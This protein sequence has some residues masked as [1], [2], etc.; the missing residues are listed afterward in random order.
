MTA[1]AA[2]LCPRH[3]DE[4]RMSLRTLHTDS[5]RPG[6]LL[7]LFECPDCGSEQRLP[8]DAEAA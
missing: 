7:G 5:A 4:V 8:F 6:Q 1:P 2:P 3:D